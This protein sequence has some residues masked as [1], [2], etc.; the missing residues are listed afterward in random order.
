MRCLKSKLLSFF[1]LQCNSFGTHQIH[2][3]WDQV[4]MKPSLQTFKGVQAHIICN[5]IFC[6]SL[7]DI[8]V[9]DISIS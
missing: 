8:P 4:C 9:S 1:P 7:S 6:A 5:F 3:N 2:L